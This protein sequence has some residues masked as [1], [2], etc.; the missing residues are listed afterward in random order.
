M[1]SVATVVENLDRSDVCE[2]FLNN[3]IP[4]GEY[5]NALGMVYVLEKLGQHL[6]IAIAPVGRSR[7]ARA[8]LS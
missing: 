7:N 4:V 3:G 6:P 8:A 2:L 5:E 1:H